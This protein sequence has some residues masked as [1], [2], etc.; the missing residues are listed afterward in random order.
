[1]RNRCVGASLVR[2]ARATV[3][4][5]HAPAVD[6][7]ARTSREQVVAVVVC[8]VQARQIV[9]ADIGDRA[10]LTR[11]HTCCRAPA[12][13]AESQCSC[14][15][16]VTRGEAKYRD[17]MLRGPAAAIVRGSMRGLWKRV[18]QIRR[19]VFDDHRITHA[20]ELRLVRARH[21]ERA[22]RC[23]C[24]RRARVK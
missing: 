11:L 23:C 4:S 9:I 3:R 18:A 10:W 16:P 21:D 12:R 24:D 17:A 19:K 20:M 13:A 5:A 7:I 1:M 15:F 14:G 2:R 6:A 8:V 22:L